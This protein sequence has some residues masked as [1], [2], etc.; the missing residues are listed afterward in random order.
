MMM[1][2]LRLVMVPRRAL[3]TEPFF[4]QELVEFETLVWPG[5]Q[6]LLEEF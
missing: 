6:H 3:F 5:L 2:G 1:V 4:R